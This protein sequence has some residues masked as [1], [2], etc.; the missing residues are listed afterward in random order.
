MEGK[1][2]ASIKVSIGRSKRGVI[3]KFL[4]LNL[5]KMRGNYSTKQK[6]R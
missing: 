1:G 6:N 4:F 5:Q 3:R 2:R